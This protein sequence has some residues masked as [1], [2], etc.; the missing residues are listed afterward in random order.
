MLARRMVSGIV[1][2][3]ARMYGHPI[4]LCVSTVVSREDLVVI[5][6]LVR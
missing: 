2:A 5:L 6:G 3:A 4:R 1:A